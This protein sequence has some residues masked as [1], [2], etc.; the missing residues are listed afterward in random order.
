METKQDKVIKRWQVT[1]LGGSNKLEKGV[2]P[3]DNHTLGSLT[4]HLREKSYRHNGAVDGEEHYRNDNWRI[5]LY[6]NPIKKTLRIESLS[7]STLSVA[8]EDFGLKSY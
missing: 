3:I 6:I 4:K 2:I 5:D 1:S 7:T 8:I